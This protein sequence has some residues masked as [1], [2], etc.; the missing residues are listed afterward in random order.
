MLESA[1]AE[2][3]RGHYDAARKL[4][5]E[6]S[7]LQPDNADMWYEYACVD[8]VSGHQGDALKHLEASFQSGFS[9]WKDLDK[10]NDLASLR[11][12][13]EFQSL[14]KQHREK[15]GFMG[16]LFGGGKDKPAAAHAPAPAATVGAPPAQ[17]RPTPTS[18]TPRRGACARR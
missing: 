6:V 17:T 3:A 15:K 5:E 1:A 8:A 11:K 14:V 16:G 4:Y 10:D 9:R 13:A 18:P 12:N 2:V 7:K